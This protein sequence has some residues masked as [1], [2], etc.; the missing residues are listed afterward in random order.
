MAL[1][2]SSLRPFGSTGFPVSRLGI[3]DIADR[4]LAK[5][6][7][8]SILHRAMDHGLNLIDTAPGYEGG[9]GEEVVAAALRGRREGMFV[10]DKID[11][12]DQPVTPQI[13][14]SLQALHIACADAFVFHAVASMDQWRAL[15]R[16]GGAFAE[17]NTLRAAGKL[18]FGGISA[19]H[20]EVLMAAVDSGLCDVLMFPVG[21]FVHRD[22][23]EKVLPAAKRAGIA[24]VCFKTFGA[25]KLLGDTLGYGRPL[26]ERPRGKFGSAGAAVVEAELPRLD[27][28]TCLRYT[29]TLDPDCALLGMSLPNEQDAVFEAF[30]EFTPMP[31]E[32]LV[33]T[34]AAAI[35]AIRGK[36]GAHWN[37]QPEVLE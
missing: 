7:L 2:L 20:P 10:I 31:A 29:L 33:R 3:G 25:G 23:I 27:V 4:S 36:G 6:D 14:A 16:P 22:Y 30:R 13:E 8:V 5:D 1:P 9:Y 34:H 11:F 24:T 17:L 21:P 15:A 37:P 28:A 35:E 26:R 18:R 12:L 32:E 19:H